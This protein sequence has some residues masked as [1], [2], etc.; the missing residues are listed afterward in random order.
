[1]QDGFEYMEWEYD[2]LKE[3]VLLEFLEKHGR[4]PSEKEFEVALDEAMRL[5]ELSRY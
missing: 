2:K 3:A 4:K 1:M 5:I